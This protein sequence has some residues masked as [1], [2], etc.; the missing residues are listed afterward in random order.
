MPRSLMP[1][2]ATLAAL[3]VVTFVAGA[4]MI[5]VSVALPANGAGG[6]VFASLQN[7]LP[8]GDGPEEPGWNDG[9]PVGLYLMTRYWIATRSLEKGVYYFTSDGRVF[10]D[11]EDGFSDDVL[12]QH[13]GRHGTV[14]TEGDEM[15][16]AWAD[17]R[18]ERGSLERVKGGFNWNTGL[19]APVEPFD[20][21]NHLVGRWEGGTSMTFSGSSAATSSSL[22]LRGDG[23]FTGASAASL[24]SASDESVAS[25]G[26][27][28]T[29]SGS[30]QL[31]GYSLVL[32]YDDGRTA[33]GIT[34]PFDDSETPVYP[35]R[36]YF[37][38]T[39]YKKQS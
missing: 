17:G 26:S 14:R 2:A 32:T 38:G 39:M 7:A 29:N 11:L 13:R 16:I 37:R 15:V 31:D 23:T 10:V 21:S 9:H 18:E 1:F 4:A 8:G 22:D 12:A 24:Q 33:R 20:D 34:F 36:F 6:G 3:S 35:D 25:A 28:G 27:H 19:F 30:W 5:A